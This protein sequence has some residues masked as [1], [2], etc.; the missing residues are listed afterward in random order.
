MGVVMIR[1]PR[2]G[3]EVSTGLEMDQATWDGPARRAIENA[4]PGLSRGTRVVAD[5]C[6]LRCAG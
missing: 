4:L 6:P 3:D 1:C 5:I 2:T